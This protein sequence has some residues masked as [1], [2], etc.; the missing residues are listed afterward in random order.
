MMSRILRI[1]AGVRLSRRR[2]LCR[3][4][5]RGLGAFRYLFSFLVAR[6]RRRGG[7]SMLLSGSG[8]ARLSWRLFVTKRRF[9]LRMI[10]FPTLYIA[11][12]Y[13]VIHSSVSNRL[14]AAQ[15]HTTARR[16]HHWKKLSATHV[17]TKEPF[18]STRNTRQAAPTH[19]H[20]P[21]KARRS[22]RKST[23]TR[24]NPEATPLEHEVSSALMTGVV[25]LSLK[26]RPP[27]PRRARPL[28]APRR[29]RP[30]LL[31]YPAA[32]TVVCTAL[33]M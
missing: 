25:A 19:D 29:N 3:E 8:T 30:H 9:L 22:T 12:E 20:T 5:G 27:Q 7:D 14:R 6:D 4:K 1:C 32:V 31:F 13:V 15:W 2:L 26:M 11:G 18:S 23:R 17:R 33:S 24:I 28:T 16:H 10:R 21:K